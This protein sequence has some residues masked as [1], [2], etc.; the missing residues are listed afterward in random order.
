MPGLLPESY[1]QQLVIIFKKRLPGIAA[2]EGF[3]FIAMSR[4]PEIINFEVRI[5]KTYTWYDFGYMSA[6]QKVQ[7][8]INI[9]P[10]AE[11]NGRFDLILYNKYAEQYGLAKTKQSL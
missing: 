4:T 5:L 6:K 3:L 11:K 7:F 2:W 8:L 9:K 1:A 10:S